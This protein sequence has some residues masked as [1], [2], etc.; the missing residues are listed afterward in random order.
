[1]PLSCEE[2]EKSANLARGYALISLCSAG[3]GHSGGTLSV[4]DISHAL[5]MNIMNHDPKN[6]SWEERDRCI[7]SSGHKAPALYVN[8]AM[9]GYDIFPPYNPIDALMTLRKFS[10]PLEGHP[11]C[12]KV[13]GVEV[14]TGSL[15]Q[16]L[17]IAVGMALS[18]KLNDKNYNVFCLTGDGEHQEGSIWEAAMSAAHYRLDN[19]VNIVDFNGLQIDGFVKDIMNI[20]SLKA[21]Y[22]AFNWNALVINGHNMKEILEAFD[23]T[24]K[25]EGKPTVIIAE[26]TK[27]KGVKF[28]E[29]IAGWHGITPNKE[30]LEQALCDLNLEN[31]LTSG[32]VD[33]LLKISS[34]YQ[35]SIV[36]PKILSLVP[37]FS[38]NYFWNAEKKYYLFGSGE[39]MKIK[40][41]PTRF[42]FGRC[43]EK[44]GDDERIVCLGADISGS[45]KMSDFCEKHPKRKKRFI[46]IGIAEQNMM[47]VAAGLANEGNIP[48]TGTYGVF[49]SGRCW[50]QLRTTVCYSNLN[51]KIAGAHG[52]VSVG[53]DGATHQSLE[54]ISLM[55][56]LPNMRLAVPSDSIETEKA[57]R[58]GFLEL[59]GPFYTRFGREAVPIITK[60]DTP[61]VFGKANIMRYRGENENFADAFETFISDE[62][63]SE[64]EDVSII[65]C[66]AMVAEAMR[67]AY[68]LKEEHKLE[69]RVINL[70]TIKPIDEPAIINAVNNT[71]LILTVEEH[72]VGGFGNIV[73]GVATKIMT[74]KEIHMIGVDDRFGQSGNPWEL[75]YAF[76]L[77]AEHIAKAVE[78]LYFCES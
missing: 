70:H 18:G 17:G 47:A 43:L 36:N 23:K 45:I 12:K 64:N 25:I 52:G 38:K 8:L 57:C 28:M 11:N 32:E 34:D 42:G 14:S 69:T 62:Y 2:L 58:H 55:A 60:E 16:G 48:I 40:M 21:K 4:M 56:V 76:G 1:M 46:H 54:E 35:E 65:A 67:A 37:S 77:S 6:P 72:Q 3:S 20:E 73:A 13:P 63:K 41:E 24:N 26:T 78:K 71:N 75:T 61:Y 30:Q 29:N 15:G 44:I 51:V 74:E 22:E 66:G 50:D 53:A 33:R 59:T 7:W 68:I 5:Y 31:M 49:A 39:K 19:L 9:S 10:S 27:G